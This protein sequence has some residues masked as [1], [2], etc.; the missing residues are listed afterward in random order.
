MAY[1]MDHKYGGLAVIFNHYDFMGRYKLRKREG[2]HL[3]AAKLSET[4][5]NLG[6]EVREHKDLTVSDIQRELEKV[7][8]WYD[9][10]DHAD[11][12]CLVVAVLTHGMDKEKLQAR[13]RAY[14]V[15]MLFTPFINCKG[16]YGTPKLF[17]LQACKSGEGTKFDAGTRVEYVDRESGDSCREEGPGSSNGDRGADVNDSSCDKKSF[18]ASCLPTQP[19]IL[20]SYATFEGQY[21]FRSE[22]EGTPY[23]N[24][25]C[26]E[27]DKMTPDEDLLSVLTRVNR[28]VGLTYRS[29]NPDNPKQH[30]KVQQPCYTST[31]TGRLYFPRSASSPN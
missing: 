6:F 12:H 13:D 19:D 31:L 9:E 2:T 16:L 21:A 28:A 27:L 8:Q 15:S 25:L 30:Q 11:S 18:L 1:R 26:A 29:K 14:D 24:H 17:F 22:E 7:A 4:F 23:V 10:G 20:I 5:K 3:D